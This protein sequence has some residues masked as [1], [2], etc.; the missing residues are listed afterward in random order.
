MAQENQNT[1]QGVLPQTKLKLTDLL[2]EEDQP[3]NNIALTW[4]QWVKVGVL[5][6]LFVALNWWQFLNLNHRYLSDSNWTHGY[7]IPLFSLYLIYIN[8]N[9]IFAVKRKV[10]FWGIPVMVLSFLTLLYGKIG[11]G[12]DWIPQLMMPFMIFGM[13][14]FLGGAKFAW[15]LRVPIFF[16][17]LMMPISQGWYTAIALPLQ[18]I[19]AFMS[20]KILALF[21]VSVEVTASNIAIVSTSGKLQSL[22]V[23]EACSGVKSLMAFITLGI[24]LAV[25][26]R[27]PLWQKLVIVGSALPITVICN[28][29]RVAITANMFYLD[30]P[31]LG[32]D[33]MHT[34]TGMVLLIPA[35]ILLFAVGK[36]LN[37]LYVEVDDDEDDSDS[38]KSS[39]SEPGEHTKAKKAD[40]EVLDVK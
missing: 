15:V 18:N 27:R 34:A 33:F 20:G 21:G 1:G 40:S 23:A 28:I 4:V 29:I 9:E 26:E 6:L 17:L 35:M 8:R 11:I 39:E 25:I 37:M 12:N 2:V 14:M 10:C 30:K 13:V 7:I 36:I 3:A 24:V 22:D 32:E 38:K 16:L 19:A 5:T 31:E